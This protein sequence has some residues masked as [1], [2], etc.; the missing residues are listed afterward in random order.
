MR[1][2]DWE[3]KSIMAGTFGL[4]GGAMFGVV[5]RVLWEK[6]LPPDASNRIPMAMRLLAARGHDRIVLVDVGAGKGYSDKDRRIYDFRAEDRL[7][8]SLQSAGFRSNDVTD[9]VITHLHFDHGA[10]VCEPRP[11]G[12]GW[13]LV[14]PGARHHVQKSQYEH[15][16]VPNARDR[17]SYYRDRVEIMEREGVLELHEGPWALAPD[18]DVLVFDGHTPGQQLPKVSGGGSTVLF[19]GDLIPTQHHIATPYI[20]S[21]DLNP[22]LSMEEKVPILE[23]AYEEGWTLFFEHD[24]HLAACRLAREDGRLTAGEPVTL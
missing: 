23:R 15:A 4:D 8:E 19:C 14:F 1:I 2:V 5:P 22:V 11:G 7:V 9:V 3:T 13:Q 24:A 12:R 20:M 18:F 21:Y 16:L 6:R 10:G 17:A